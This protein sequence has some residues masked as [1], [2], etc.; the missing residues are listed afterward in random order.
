ML[1]LPGN[2]HPQQ[3]LSRLF[4]AD[5]IIVDDESAQKSQLA[6]LLKFLDQLLRTLQPRPPPKGHDNVAEFTFK[7]AAA[8]KLDRPG[9]VAFNFEQIESWRRQAGQVGRLRL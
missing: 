7:R 4:V 6:Q 9:R 5:K 3:F 8:R 1:L 2:N